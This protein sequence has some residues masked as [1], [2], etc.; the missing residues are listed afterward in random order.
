MRSHAPGDGGEGSGE[1]WKRASEQVFSS[2]IFL[3][4]FFASVLGCEQLVS[5]DNSSRQWYVLDLIAKYQV[6]KRSS[7]EDG[8]SD[9]LKPP[10]DRVVLE[11][12]RQLSII[13]LERRRKITTT[14][15]LLWASSSYQV[16]PHLLTEFC[17]NWTGNFLFQQLLELLAFLQKCIF[18]Q[19]WK[20]SLLP[21]TFSHPP[22]W[23]EWTQWR[24]AS[25]AW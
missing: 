10:F 6:F 1:F 14:K 5:K 20:Q 7:N 22:D 23:K 12:N 2:S 16:I 4:H 8:T 19:F 21:A 3:V 18:D 11:L 24:G 17:S 25:L 9:V 13:I 15:N